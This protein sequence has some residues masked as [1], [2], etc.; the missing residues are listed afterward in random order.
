MPLFENVCPCDWDADFGAEGEGC[1][2][3]VPGADR[4]MVFV[5]LDKVETITKT[6]A[7]DTDACGTGVITAVALVTD[8]LGFKVVAKQDSI[9]PNSS[10]TIGDN[11]SVEI[12]ENVPFQGTVSTCNI[13]WLN[14][15]LGKEGILFV[16]DNDDKLWAFG[17]NGGG[18][19]ISFNNQWGQQSGDFKG[20]DVSYV[21][22]SKDIACEVVPAT[23]TVDEFLAGLIA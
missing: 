18:R 2:N 13:N 9:N 1:D 21:N 3:Q 10:K 16:K 11:N 17:W 7:D 19:I 23:G 20:V 5:C 8:E 22:T 6:A 12:D 14:A 4:V 15:H